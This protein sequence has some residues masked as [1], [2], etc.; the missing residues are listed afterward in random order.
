MILVTDAKEVGH[1]IENFN[2]LSPPSVPVHGRLQSLPAKSKF[3][4]VAVTLA[5]SFM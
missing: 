4:A 3:L 1:K 2:P 5:G